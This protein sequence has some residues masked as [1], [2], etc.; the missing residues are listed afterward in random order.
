LKKL[1]YRRIPLLAW[2]FEL[3]ASHGADRL[4][5][6]EAVVFPSGVESIVV[7]HGVVDSRIL[8]DDPSP[9][10]IH[11]VGSAVA[12]WSLAEPGAGEPFR[13]R[14]PALISNDGD[15]GDFF[16]VSEHEVEIV[17][18]ATFFPALEAVENDK[19]AGFLS[20]RGPFP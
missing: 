19:Q 2:L 1:C 15:P 17:P 18:I 20:L 13:L 9:R 5:K 3:I 11:T 8:P 16:P 4:E 14:L 7:A 12:D 10:F 6:H